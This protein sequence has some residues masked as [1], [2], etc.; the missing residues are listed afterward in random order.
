MDD[1]LI[2]FS[3]CTPLAAG[4]TASDASSAALKFEWSWTGDYLMLLSQAT[5]SESPSGP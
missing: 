3:P 2:Q 5:I 1:N 4:G